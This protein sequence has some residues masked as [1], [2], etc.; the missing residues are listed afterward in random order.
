MKNTM[1]YRA[2]EEFVVCSNPFNFASIAANLPSAPALL[3]MYRFGNQP[4]ASVF[5][6]Y[7]IMKL[8]KEAGTT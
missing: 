2:L 6:G 3:G 1:E 4:I 8:F 5:S 7:Y